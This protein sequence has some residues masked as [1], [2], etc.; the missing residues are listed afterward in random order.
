[1]STRLRFTCA[2][3]ALAVA[4]LWAAVGLGRLEVDSELESL[5]PGDDP[6]VQAL[7]NMA[8]TFG[9]D[10]VVVLVEGG[11]DPLG[12]DRLLDLLRL[13]GEL[14]AVDGVVATYGPATTLNQTVLR[15][16]QMIADLM[17]QRDA[18][19]QAGLTKPLRL[20]DQRYGALLV[21]AMPAGLPTLSNPG[22]VRS[23]VLDE[24]S[25]RTQPQW[26][27]YL[28]ADETVAIYLRPREGLDQ[29]AA[30][31]L[32]DDV[33]DV[34][35]GSAAVPDDAEVTV[36]G[37]PVVTAGLADR[38]RNELPKLAVAAFVVVAAVLLLVPW[39][40]RRR[41]RLAPLLVM[42]GATAGTLAWFGWRDEPLSI[43]AAT[44][45]PIIL[46]LGSYY[47]VYL[48]R[49]GHR[50]VV[51]AVAAS[52]AFAFGGLVLSPLPFVGQLGVA[53]PLGLALVVAITLVASWARGGPAPAAENDRPVR[54]RPPTPTAVLVGMAVLAVVGSGIG[55]AALSSADLRTD[56]QQLLAGVP[57]LDDAA[58]VED[59]LGYS[60]EIDV[61]LRGDDV[62]APEALAWSREA[63]RRV[64]SSY[65][66]RVRPVV[67]VSQLLGF[68]GEDPTPAQIRAGV[69]SLPDYVTS[70]VVSADGEQALTSY[71][72]AWS[73]LADDREL[74][75]ELREA[76][77]PPPQGYTVEVSGLPVAAERGYE[78]VSADRY[79]PNLI[80]LLAAFLA[81]VV[82]VPNRRDAVLAVLAAT[83]AT[84]LTL[85]VMTVAVGALNPLTLALG[86]LTAA[87]GAEFTV[88]LLVADRARDH[89]LRR[90]VW[91]AALLSLGG[92]GV[93][94]AS[95]LPVLR[96]LG[97]ALTTSVAL[98]VSTALALTALCS[99][100]A[101]RAVPPT[102]PE[103]DVTLDD[104]DRLQLTG[105]T[106]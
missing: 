25:G 16:K 57:E 64:V 94:L 80:A 49:P 97:L 65:G 86:A 75:A 56:P 18:L 76:L 11:G 9:G 87:V 81:L 3:A 24:Q 44:F 54:T 98:S 51:L 1:V 59:V 84:G 104:S 88:L 15:I 42:T 69:A 103:A 85:A 48:V 28:P 93:L 79:E 37:V 35:D 100:T 63:E 101:R 102:D 40:S 39:T 61:R 43:G 68:L 26:Q 31:D 34:L 10:P 92:Y 20:F 27:Q 32:T 67:T 60:G 14:S 7:D 30:A 52:A 74:V 66:D 23:V 53:V 82:L 83:V 72:V 45:L 13:E 91:L 99:R 77:P 62:L 95:S 8:E 89:V 73:D 105:G 78:L 22:F 5:L 21:Q 33:R 19:E 50:R 55:W 29:Q 90:S 46:G 47:P 41:W 58:H 17:G 4:A 70:A 36:T 38:L 12:E 6:T 71:G 2:A 96:E 106:P